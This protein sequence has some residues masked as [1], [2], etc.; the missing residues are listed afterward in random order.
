MPDKIWRRVKN[1]KEL[2]VGLPVRCV[3]PREALPEKSPSGAL[4]T[5]HYKEGVIITA[6]PNR[7]PIKYFV[8]FDSGGILMDSLQC[9]EV[10]EELKR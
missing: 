3:F 9:V 10:Q 7:G 5:M 6:P 8:E 1:R 2:T 4:R